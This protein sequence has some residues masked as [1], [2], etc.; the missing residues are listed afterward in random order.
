MST[1]AKQMQTLQ[2]LIQLL[3]QE[4]AFLLRILLELL[5]RVAMEPT[6][7]MTADTLGTL[8]APHLLVPRT[9]NANDLQT[10]SCNVTT[11]VSFMITHHCEMFEYPVTLVRDI[12]LYWDDMDGGYMD[13]NRTS[14]SRDGLSSD[15][16]L[17]SASCPRFRVSSLYIL[18][19]INLL[20]KFTVF[21]F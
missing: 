12:Q 1:Q 13:L 11:I 14:V 2:L 15:D 20:C 17:D 10:E 7:K 16:D 6:N 4:N 8:F 19:V 21:F 9:T 3:P 5:H 18:I